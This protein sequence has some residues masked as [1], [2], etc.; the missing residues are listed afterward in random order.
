MLNAHKCVLDWGQAC[1]GRHVWRDPSG[2]SINIHDHPETKRLKFKM[3]FIAGPPLNLDQ[4]CKVTHYIGTLYSVDPRTQDL[5]TGD[6][7]TWG[8]RTQGP[9]LACAIH[10]CTGVSICST[11]ISRLVQ[12]NNLVTHS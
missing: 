5:G 2:N 11:R 9:K 6:P 12:W 1:W 8:P 4:I 3:E 10:V 7:G